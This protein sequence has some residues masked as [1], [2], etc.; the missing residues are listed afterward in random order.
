MNAVISKSIFTKGNIVKAWIF[1]SILFFLCTSSCFGKSTFDVKSFIKFDHVTW[2]GDIEDE[3]DIGLFARGSGL[4]IVSRYS[5]SLSYVIQFERIASTIKNNITQTY[6]MYEHKWWTIKFGK[7]S[8]PVGLQGIGDSNGMFMENSLL[9]GC[10]D[11]NFIG[12]DI[13]FDLS[14]AKLSVLLVIPSSVTSSDKISYIV[15]GFTD[16]KTFDDCSVH[17]GVNTR[18][19]RLGDIFNGNDISRKMMFFHDNSSFYSE[20]TFR[21]CYNYLSKYTVIGVEYAANVE[22]FFVQT[23]Y[24]KISALWETNMLEFYDSYYYQIGVCLTGESHSYDGRAG[25]Y[26]DPVPKRSFGALELLYRF[27]CYNVQHY[28]SIFQAMSDYDGSKESRVFALN[29]YFNLNMKLQFNYAHELTYYRQN[30][31]KPRSVS[32]IGVRLQFNF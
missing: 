22:M 2:S 6:I 28:H 16:F 8:I 4:S 9:L 18:F 26:R 13:Y 14:L 3:Y 31:D 10:E 19:M 21:T 7:L 1:I 30:P 24:S 20:P 15:R 11:R 5:D 29:W 23:E 27:S 25:M 17:V 32:G 12:M